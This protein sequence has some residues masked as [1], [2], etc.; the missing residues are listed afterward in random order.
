[1]TITM[2]TSTGGDFLSRRARFTK[3]HSKCTLYKF[4]STTLPGSSAQH[5]HGA[6][7]SIVYARER[8]RGILRDHRSWNTRRE[9][10]VRFYYAIFRLSTRTTLSRAPFACTC[11]KQPFTL[12]VK[13]RLTAY[14]ESWGPTVPE[15]CRSAS[16]W[17]R[18]L[19]VERGNISSKADKS[20]TWFDQ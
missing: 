9:M 6:L 2:T 16:R 14:Y 5:D 19:W 18:H 3:A 17:W 7:R 13:C 12:A 4:H 15:C 10:C 20:S 1:M 11:D 8:R